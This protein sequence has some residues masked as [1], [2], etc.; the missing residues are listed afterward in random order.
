[1]GRSLHKKPDALAYARSF[2]V[3]WK[4]RLENDQGAEFSNDKGIGQQFSKSFLSLFLRYA[5]E[6]WPEKL[7]KGHYELA[8]R[9]EKFRAAHYEEIKRQIKHEI[10]ITKRTR[11]FLIALMSES[12]SKQKTGRPNAGG[13]HHLLAVVIH[14]ASLKFDLSIGE[15]DYSNGKSAQAAVIIALSD[16]FPDSDVD[17]RDVGVFLQNKRNRETQLMLQNELNDVIIEFYGYLKKFINTKNIRFSPIHDELTN[18]YLDFEKI[19]R[20]VKKTRGSLYAHSQ[21]MLSIKESKYFHEI[22]QFFDGNCRR[23]RY[24]EKR[25]NLRRY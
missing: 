15:E 10:L 3:E 4:N 20:T 17:Y 24:S 16:L 2:L 18:L 14:N 9:D 13:W 6:N 11:N 12:S 25:C 7:S 1:M 23:K 22:A 8:I 19:I 21:S 5:H